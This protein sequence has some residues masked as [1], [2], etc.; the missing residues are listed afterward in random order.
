M[1]SISSLA[2]FIFILR[3]LY[4]NLCNNFICLGVARLRFFLFIIVF[5]ILRCS[6]VDN[7]SVSMPDL[8]SHCNCFGVKGL[9][10]H[11]L[12]D[13]SGSISNTSNGSRGFYLYA[14]LARTDFLIS[15]SLS[16]SSLALTAASALSRRDMVS[17]GVPSLEAILLASSTTDML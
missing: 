9:T 11:S 1:R 17:M 13:N 7:I 4:P 2:S 14:T 10:F 15:R 6:P 3:A 12:S 16:A 5:R 8:S